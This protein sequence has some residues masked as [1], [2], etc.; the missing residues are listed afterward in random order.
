MLIF[1]KYAIHEQYDINAC[2]ALFSIMG[3]WRCKQVV[4]SG[5][6][7]GGGT[8]PALL[9]KGVANWYQIAIPVFGRQ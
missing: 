9:F 3:M 8:L 6:P 5:D 4:W 1:T 7:Q 2:E